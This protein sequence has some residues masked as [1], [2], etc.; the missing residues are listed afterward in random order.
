[1]AEDTSIKTRRIAK[2]TV[3]LYIRSLFNLFVSL[4]TSRLILQALGVD[5]YGVYGVVGS[6]VGMFSIASNALSGAISR[7]LNYEMGKGNKEE[8]AKVFSLSITIM[9]IISV[10]VLLLTE[11]FGLWFLNN[12]MTIPPGRET[13]AFWCFQFS[14]LASISKFL[15]IPFN[16]SIIAHEK[17]D[18]YAYI[19]IFEVICHLFIALY[20]A[21]GNPSLDVLVAYAG[22]WLI[23]TLTIQMISRIYAI[24]NFKECRFKWYFEKDR[25]KELF[26][27]A[28]WSF[29]GN[30]STT[31]A[32]QGVNMILNV[33][34]GPVVNAARSLSG[35]VN[36]TVQIFVNNFTMAIKPQITQSYAAGEREYMKSLLFRGTK[37]TFFIM[38]LIAF[39]LFLETSFVVTLWLGEFPE[40]T[41]N[42]I[43][44][45]LVLNTYNIFY[46]IFINGINATGKIRVLQLWIS[47]TNFAL[48]PISYVM[49]HGGF[50]PEWV[51][52]VNLCLSVVRTGIVLTICHK[53]LGFTPR[54][55]VEKVYLKLILVVLVSTVIPLPIYLKMSEGWLRFVT[56]VPVCIAWSGLVILFVGC[57]TS[58]RKM[59]LTLIQEKVCG[60]FAR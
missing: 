5:D 45:S 3:M 56:I 43:R 11:T 21:F 19:G 57:D 12:R 54:E 4:Y 18:I 31:F 35:T 52:I 23:V 59:L 41:L 2:N 48:F 38:F 27:Y 34:F 28:G 8:L 16:S 58:E 49:M 13:A 15:V 7:T 33:V 6:F 60:R 32:G 55:V 1:M 10:I 30:T 20:L 14:I 51:Y 24:R 50:P 42:F 25:F 22:L 44:L 47:I 40:H 37:F 36:N 17:M 9:G 29:I 26:S 53:Q 39:P 46:V